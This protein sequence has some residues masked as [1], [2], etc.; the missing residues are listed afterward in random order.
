MGVAGRLAVGLVLGLLLIVA[1]IALNA[2]RQPSRQIAATPAPPLALDQNAAARRLGEAV[3]IRTVSF[4]PALPPATEE[5][6]RL[7]AFLEASFPKAH[8]A[9]KRETVGGLSLL[10]AW[11]GRDAGAA[12]AMLMAHQDVVPIAPGTDGDWTVPPFSGELRDG[13]VWGRGAWDDKGSLMAIMEAVELLAARGFRPRRTLYLAFGHDE[14]LGGR[15]G[16]AAIAQLLH[17]RGVR[18]D[19]VL[20]EGLVITQGVLKGLDRPLALIGVAEKG[21]LT[22]EL[23][24]MGEPGHSSIP[25]RQSAIGLLSAALVRLEA[26]QA[27]AKLTD[28]TH[29]MLATVAPEMPL[30]TRAMM[31]NLWLFGPLVRRE[32]EKSASSNA[33][34]RTTAALTVVQAGEKEN[35]LP[36][37]AQGLVNY[38]MLPGDTA[39][40]V[41]ERTRQA[42]GPHV[43]VEPLA[44]ATEASPVS[45]LTSSGYRAIER[46]IR[47]VFAD[48][49]VAPGLMVGGTDAKHMLAICDNVFRFAPVRAQPHDLARFH[50]TNERIS[51]ENYAEMIRFFHR[52]IENLA[53]A[54][55]R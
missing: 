41:I 44:G 7:H 3:A 52:L 43:R 49:V 13:F 4:S 11:P 18:L 16:A 45:P 23:T 53:A 42:V 46:S 30:L 12:P 27:P 10:Y 31:S 35:V 6:R 14:E 5:F 22:L 15:N 47:E 25:P 29:A 48:A 40:A 38:R 51:V 54:A 8:A 2:W 32:L 17:S 19:F 24:A 9:L 20:D 34:V 33:I 36:G 28:V 26:K 39:Q 55:A 37:R 1:A 21:F 50:G